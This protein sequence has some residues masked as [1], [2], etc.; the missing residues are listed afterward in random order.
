MRYGKVKK[1]ALNPE[2][3]TTGSYDEN[4]ML[5]SIIYKVEFEERYVKEYSTNTI[6]DNMLSQ[7]DYYGLT[8]TMMEGIIDYQKDAATAVTKDDMYIVTNR[9]Q[10][11]IWKTTVGWQLLVQWQERSESWIHFKDLKQSHTI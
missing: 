11:E 10:K 1:Q 2:G 5:K 7:V 9:G 4:T 3:Q 8:L 6:A